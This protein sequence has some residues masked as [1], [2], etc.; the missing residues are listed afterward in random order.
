MM[1]YRSA[2]IVPG[3]N[4]PAGIESEDIILATWGVA[5]GAL[6]GSA[7]V[8]AAVG[9]CESVLI[10]CP[11]DRQNLL[12]RGICTEHFGHCTIDGEVIGIWRTPPIICDH[13]QEGKKGCRNLGKIAAAI[14]YARIYAGR[15]RQK[16]SWCA[17]QLTPDES[18]SAMIP[19]HKSRCG[20]E[21][22]GRQ[23]A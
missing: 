12:S 15:I 16:K 11:Q 22:G 2:R 8:P 1:R 21:P 23:I 5:A 9:I 3:V 10:G 20:K 14:S 6:A 4:P 13:L 17:E 18:G 7:A 19:I